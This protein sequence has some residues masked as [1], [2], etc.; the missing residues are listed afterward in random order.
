MRFHETMR[1]GSRNSGKAEKRTPI[2]VDA[3][4]KTTD[5]DP[6]GYWYGQHTN[7]VRA[8]RRRLIKSAGGIRQFKKQMRLARIERSVIKT[9][10][11]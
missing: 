4:G 11:A 7:Q 2:V 6:R 3:N 10:A 8:A 5:G 9:E 1:A